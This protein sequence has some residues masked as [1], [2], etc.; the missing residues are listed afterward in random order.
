MRSAPGTLPDEGRGRVCRVQPGRPLTLTA[1]H[2]GTMDV[3]CASPGASALFSVRTGGGTSEGR[4][5]RASFDDLCAPWEG[6]GGPAAPPKKYPPPPP[7][8]N[9]KGRNEGGGGICGRFRSFL[10]TFR[11][12]STIHGPISPIFERWFLPFS[13]PKRKKLF[14]LDLFIFLFIF[15]D[16][17]TQK[18]KWTKK[19]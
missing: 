8:P 12:C 7:P 18:K 6:R 19:H 16:C 9:K 17:F 5:P 3:D 15:M 11:P 1:H 10:T 14:L 13:R 4:G 2:S